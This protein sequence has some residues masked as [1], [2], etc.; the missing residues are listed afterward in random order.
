MWLGII[1]H[2]LNGDIYENFLREELPSFIP[3]LPLALRRDMYF[4]HDGCAAHYRRS[5]RVWLDANYPNEWIGRGGSIAWPAKSPDLMLMDFYV[6]WGHMK[7]IV[8]DH[9]MLIVKIADFGENRIH[10]RK[11]P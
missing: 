4:Q 9:N 1:S 6:W 2:N 7:S 5:V 11:R 8:Y 3:D 10:R